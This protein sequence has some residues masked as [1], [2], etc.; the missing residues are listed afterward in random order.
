MKKRLLTYKD[1][2]DEYG[3]TIW[4]WRSLVWERKLQIVTVGRKHFI[5]RVDA[6]ALI[7]QNKRLA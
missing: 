7:A 2:V 3:G 5:D 6:D 4:F 1:L